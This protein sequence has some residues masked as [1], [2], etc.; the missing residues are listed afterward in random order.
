MQQN[1]QKNKVDEKIINLL[2]KYKKNPPKIN[3]SYLKNLIG[4][5]IECMLMMMI[6]KVKL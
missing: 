5:I 4:V 1:L 6:K 2:E 3:G